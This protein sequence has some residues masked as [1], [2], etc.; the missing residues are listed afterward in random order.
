MNYSGIMP[1]IKNNEILAKKINGIYNNKKTFLLIKS[2]F[3]LHFFNLISKSSNRLH[4]V[5]VILFL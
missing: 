2:V 5:L 1:Y 3:L 4:V